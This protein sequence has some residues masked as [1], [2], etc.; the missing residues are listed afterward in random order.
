M[1]VESENQRRQSLGLQ[2]IPQLQTGKHKA[3]TYGLA[4]LHGKETR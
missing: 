3:E 4:N 2:K 1:K